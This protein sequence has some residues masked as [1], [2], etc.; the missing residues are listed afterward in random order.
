VANYG[1]STSLHLLKND[2]TWESHS[3]PITA[4]RYPTDLLV[5]EYGYVWMILNPSQGG[6]ILVYDREED[7]YAYLINTIGAGGLP[8]KNVRSIARDRDGYVWVGTDQGVAY[9]IYPPEVFEPGIDAIK[10][11]FENRFLLKDD[12][13]TAIKVDGGNRKWMATERGVWLF[14]AVGEKDIYNFTAANSPLLSD[15]VRDVEIVPTTGEVF[16]ATDAGIVSFRSGATSSESSFQTVKIFPNPVTK[17]FS[18]LVGISGLAT[19]AIVKITDVSGKLIW[20]TQANGGTATW[21]VQDYKGRRAATGIYLVFA[22][23][24]DGS[25]SVVGKLAVID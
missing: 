8:S 6:G 4:A 16:F 18:G 12:K 25:E 1:A 7:R 9:F 17:E 23:T 24:S 5:D 11:I 19:D 15:L 22:A 21:N 13:V 2:G 3:F 20:Q 14:D 10:P